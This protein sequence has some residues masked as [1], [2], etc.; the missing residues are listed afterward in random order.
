MDK[1]N[2]R[3]YNAASEIVLAQKPGSAEG[4]D[5][6]RADAAWSLEADVPRVGLLNFDWVYAPG[7]R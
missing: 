1:G 4:L 6:C 5:E 2:T 7:A 3:G